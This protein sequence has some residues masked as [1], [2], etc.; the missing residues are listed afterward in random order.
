MD[1]T[2]NTDS[3]SRR[4]NEQFSRSTSHPDVGEDFSYQSMESVELSVDDD[5][6]HLGSLRDELE[7]N[8]ECLKI[9]HEHEI[10]VLHDKLEREKKRRDEAEQMYQEAKEDWSKCL[11]E[12]LRLRTSTIKNVVQ[13]F[14]IRRDLG[15]RTKDLVQQ[16]TPMNDDDGRIPPH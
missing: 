2:Q 9:Q 15:R 11:A 1:Q 14:N 16:C 12:N 8:L 7:A 5:Q 3:Y 13:T 4:P 6:T 10:N